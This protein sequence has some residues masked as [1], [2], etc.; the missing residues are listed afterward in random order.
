M[1]RGVVNTLVIGHFQVLEL[2]IRQGSTL[3][4]LHIHKSSWTKIH[5]VV[6]RFRVKSYT[7]SLTDHYE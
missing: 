2:R 1:V 5:L 7:L 6:A 4:H 3:S